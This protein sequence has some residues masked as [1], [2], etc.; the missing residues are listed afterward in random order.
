MVEVALHRL[1]TLVNQEEESLKHEVVNCDAVTKVVEQVP[2][3]VTLLEAPTR[4]Y[5][6]TINITSNNSFSCFMINNYM[7]LQ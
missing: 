2:M 7:S 3:K 4:W 5:L 6:A 1:T